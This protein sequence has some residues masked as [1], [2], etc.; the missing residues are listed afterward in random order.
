MRK[1]SN[2]L[3]LILICFIGI[4]S[5]D[6]NESTE[7][8]YDPNSPVVFSDFLP[9]TG[10]V[11]TRLF[12]EGKN[13]GKDISKI[14]VFVGD[15]ELK[16]IGSDGNQI[17][18]MVPKQVESGAVKV[19][20]DRGNG[21]EHVFDEGFT[22]R[23]T[24]T[25]GT[26]VGDVDELGNSSII[27][28]GF[29]AARFSNPMW[30]L[31]EPVSN[32]LFVVETAL[33]VRKVDLNDESISTLITNGQASFKKIQTISLSF[34]NDT[35]FLTDDNGQTNNKNQ[36]A[37]AYTLRSEN[38]RRVHPYIY[39]YTS[40]ACASHPTDNIM[41][42]NTYIGGGIL[43]A[44]T[45]PITKELASK[46]LFKVGGTSNIKP[47]IFFH[48]SG[49]YAYFMIAQTI[50]K[51]KYNWETKELEFPIVFAGGSSGDVD[52]IGTTAKFGYIRQGVFVKN[53]AYAGQE[54]E[55]DFYLA[56]I[57]NHSIR[58]VT[59]TGEVST[60]AGKGSPSSDGKK[61]GYID[62]DLRLEAR[63][64]KPSGIAYDAERKIFYITEEVNRRIRTISVE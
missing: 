24:S 30:V 26:L 47:N 6:K 32:N 5:C 2:Y 62:G 43:K 15:K 51:S 61:E 28:G 46:E 44:F 10:A 27:D 64:N 17:Y 12:I 31:F 22:Y 13:F 33:S 16:V 35:L 7:A 52:A 60:Y 25:V 53:P 18:C 56:D 55:Y 41:F 59:P 37:I 9:K 1:L 21:V 29:D 19:V 38:Y 45:D 14:H 57:N 40:Y 23:A 63:F 36:V 4:W 3:L 39:D 58:K 49:E 42:F 11:R 48:P 34:D 8:D 20:I 50:W 54:D